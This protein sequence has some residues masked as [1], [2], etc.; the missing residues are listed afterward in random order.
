[1]YSF[2]FLKPFSTI[3]TFT[4]LGSPQYIQNYNQPVMQIIAQKTQSEEDLYNKINAFRKKLNVFTLNSRSV[5]EF[6]NKNPEYCNRPEKV[7]KQSI[8]GN[9]CSWKAYEVAC[10]YHEIIKASICR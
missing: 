9:A 4:T 3:I 7:L 6:M 1:M 5:R 10:V 2:E 8:L